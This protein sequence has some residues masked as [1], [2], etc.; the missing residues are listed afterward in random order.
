MQSYEQKLK[1]YILKQGIC[2]KHL[3]F[4]KSCHSVADAAKAVG[5]KP[6]DFIKSICLLDRETFIVGIVT[7]DDRVSRNRV[8]QV[9]HITLPAIAS[10]EIVLAKTGYPIGGV[11]PF[12]FD[13]LFLIDERVMEKEF[14]YGGGGSTNALVTCSPQEIHKAN[15]GKIIRIR[16]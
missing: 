8:A 3:T 9:L 4:T 7:G 1:E 16:K 2:A 14:V 6:D 12:G 5:A 13:A 11:P 15:K 10:P